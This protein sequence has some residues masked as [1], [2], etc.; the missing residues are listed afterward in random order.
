MATP[1]NIDKFGIL[2]GDQ[3]SSTSFLTQPVP[4]DIRVVFAEIVPVKNAQGQTVNTVETKVKN[5]TLKDV[6][7][8]QTFTESYKGVSVF[9]LT[10]LSVYPPS[11]GNGRNASIAEVEFFFKKS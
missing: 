1:T 2:N 5:Y 8:F 9:E 4:K 10:I 3:D 6:S 11:N 7:N